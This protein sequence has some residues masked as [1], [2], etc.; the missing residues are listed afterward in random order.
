MGPQAKSY[1]EKGYDEKILNGLFINPD[2]TNN[3]DNSN[4]P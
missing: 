1:L 4:N 2:N 3:P